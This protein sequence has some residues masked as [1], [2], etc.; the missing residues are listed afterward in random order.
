MRSSDRDR[1]PDFHVAR[2]DRQPAA[3]EQTSASSHVN[4]A[5]AKVTLVTIAQQLIE[6]GYRQGFEQGYRQGVEQEYRQGVE[7]GVE[8]AIRHVLLR[9]LQQRFGAEVDQRIEKRI[10]TASREQL[11]VWV[12]RVLS[13]PDLADVFAD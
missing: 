13:A 2:T 5:Q 3:P 6:Q 4:S 10:D 9:L 8:Q 1:V 12:M 7:Q 11:E